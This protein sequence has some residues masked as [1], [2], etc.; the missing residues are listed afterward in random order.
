VS[1]TD[2]SGGV[3]ILGDTFLRNFVTTFD[4]ENNQ[5]RLTINK[6]APA[7]V[8]IEYKMGGWKIF[9]IIA[10]SLL[11]CILVVW[12]VCCC[13]KKRKKNRLAMGYATIGGGATHHSEEIS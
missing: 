7:G 3:Y 11:S 4:F 8:I 9:G 6:N 2:D 13:C 12:I 1:S 10:G 5:M